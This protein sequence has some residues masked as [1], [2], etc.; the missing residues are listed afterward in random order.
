HAQNLDISRRFCAS[1]LIEGEADFFDKLGLSQ[2]ERELIEHSV[3]EMEHDS[4]LD[5]NAALADMR[6][7]FIEKV[8][9]SCVVKAHASRE[10]LRSV[11]IDK[12]LTN[13]YFALPI[14]GVIMA[15]IFYLTFYVIGAYLSDL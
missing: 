1:K 8:C 11:A 6:Y 10:Y 4:G 3:I 13:R 7:N 15:L 5:R 14:F 9:K 2:N 12:V